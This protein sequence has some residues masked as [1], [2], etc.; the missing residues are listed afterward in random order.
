ML[1]SQSLTLI[2]QLQRTILAGRICYICSR[3]SGLR[4]LQPGCGRAV[5]AC[6]TGSKDGC[7]WLVAAFDLAV[8]VEVHGTDEEHVAGSTA[9]L[10]ERLVL[11]VEH[12]RECVDAGQE[13]LLQLGQLLCISLS[14]L[15]Y[16]RLLRT[17]RRT[18]TRSTTLARQLWPKASVHNTLEQLLAHFRALPKQVLAAAHVSRIEPHGHSWWAFLRA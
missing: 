1:I 2:E 7:R 16:R 3:Y 15:L 14:E 11:L 10:H 5:R 17:S 13:I 12:R 4:L 18:R 8:L 6:F 9:D